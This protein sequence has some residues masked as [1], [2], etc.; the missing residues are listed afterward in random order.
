MTKIRISKN[1]KRLFVTALILFFC[2]VFYR[3]GNVILEGKGLAFSRYAYYPWLVV[4]TLL[5]AAF[6]CQICFFLFKYAKQA[7]NIL[8]KILLSVLS[9]GI[10]AVLLYYLTQAAFIAVFRY[11][12]FDITEKYGQ[13]MFVYSSVS[14]GD[15]EYYDYCNFFVRGKEVRIFEE[16]GRRKGAKSIETYGAFPN[17]V[18]YYD[19]N[20]KYIK[21]IY[22]D[23]N[24]K[25]V[26][27]QESLWDP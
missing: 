21:S 2:V 19:E 13:K 6:I 1:V 26:S 16:Y 9:C 3:I 23:K 18:S 7:R 4:R 24:G 15:L 12:P 14:E 27:E 5:S 22:Y 10:I 25:E 20:G 11:R 17:T 8:V